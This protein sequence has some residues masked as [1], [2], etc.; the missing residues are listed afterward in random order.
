MA[1]IIFFLYKKKAKSIHASIYGIVSALPSLISYQ[2]SNT[3]YGLSPN[4][5]G[6]GGTDLTDY[7]GHNFW[8]TEIWMQP[9]VLLIEPMW[10]QQLLHYRYEKL[11]VAKDY[12]KETGYKGAR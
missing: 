3:F 10:S 7:E 12:A 4:G 8:D 9:V 11:S 1:N 2:E 5:L 6:R